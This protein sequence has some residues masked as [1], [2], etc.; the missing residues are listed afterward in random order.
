VISKQDQ[1]NNPSLNGELVPW[2]RGIKG[3]HLSPKSEFKKG[4]SINLGRIR[5]DMQG[6]KNNKWVPKIIRQCFHCKKKLSLAPNQ[7]KN[8]VRSFCNRKCWA[9]GTRGKGSP[10]FKGEE[11]V[12][13]F[14]N[15]VWQLPEYKE[16]HTKCLKN[17][18][19]HCFKCGTKAQLEVDHIKRFLHIIQEN[20]IMS[21]EDARNCKELWNTK[22]GRT[23]CRPCHRTLPTYGTTGLKK[24]KGQT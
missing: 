19:Y 23:V 10:V 11:A 5:S 9:M 6:K 14:R 4:N 21:I 12:S 1:S 13:R 3:L 2:N 24:S 17:G 20:G 15:R 7:V 16:W 22:N 18:K 8:R